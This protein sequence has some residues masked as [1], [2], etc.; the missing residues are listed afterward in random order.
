MTF[1]PSQP[2]LKS[3]LAGRDT[4]DM[5]ELK[6]NISSLTMKLSALINASQSVINAWIMWCKPSHTHTHLQT[7]SCILWDVIFFFKRFKLCFFC[8][9]FKPKKR[10]PS[11]QFFDFLPNLVITSFHSSDSSPFSYDI[12]GLPT[13]EDEHTQ[14][15]ALS[16]HFSIH[17]F[18]EAHDWPMLLSNY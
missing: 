18:I 17:K 7:D 11:V 2:T 4:G 15:T 12:S 9:T 10:K 13:R 14:K 8:I 1:T 6:S 3:V 5:A 16:S